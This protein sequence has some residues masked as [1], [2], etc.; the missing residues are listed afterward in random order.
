M[1]AAASIATGKPT[2]RA[3]AALR[4]SFHCFCTIATARAASGPNSGPTAIAPTIRTV[5]SVT[6]PML[7]SRVARMRKARK[8][9]VSR[10]SSPVC[11]DTSSQI[12]ASAPSPGASAVAL[13]ARSEST[14]SGM[15]TEIEPCSWTY[16]TWSF[17]TSRSTDSRASRTWITSPGGRTDAPASARAA[18]IGQRIY[19]SVGLMLWKPAWKVPSVV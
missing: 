15:M 4:P 5:E 7:T 13:S 16:R 6:M 1:K 9:Q 17:S 10:E 11:R 8:L 3:S 14:T 19:D 12:T 2:S 18:V